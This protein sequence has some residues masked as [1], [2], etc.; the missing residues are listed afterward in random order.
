MAMEHLSG[1]DLRA[2]LRRRGALPVDEAC[3]LCAQ[4]LDGLHAAHGAGIVHRD[5]KPEN[6]FRTSNGQVKVLDFG[7]AKQLDS[8]QLDPALRTQV[9]YVLGTPR[10]MSPEHLM[11]PGPSHA[12]DTYAVGCILFEL[13]AGVPMMDAPSPY[14]LLQRIVRDPAPTLAERTGRRFPPAV[15]AAIARAVAKDT[16]ARFPSAAAMASELRRIA[17]TVA[18]VDEQ[19]TVDNPAFDGSTVEVD[20]RRVALATAGDAD[21][22]AREID[23]GEIL[24]DEAPTSLMVSRFT[25]EEA[26]SAKVRAPAPRASATPLA[27]RVSAMPQAPAVRVQAAAPPPRERSPAAPAPSSTPRRAPRGGPSPWLLAVVIVPL[28]F[29]ISFWWTLGAIRRSGAA[30]GDEAAPRGAPA[31]TDVARSAASAAVR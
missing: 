7:F 15:E 5:V 17:R 31:A 20:L 16:A 3:E 19:A 26:A 13:I 8:I 22:A 14:E 9:G 4:A 18:A 1:E 6:L 29:V 21:G 10:Y 11:G 28:A 30:S 24:F 23:P 25:D 2:M 27:A 12:T